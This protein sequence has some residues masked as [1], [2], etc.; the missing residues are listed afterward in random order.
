[1]INNNVTGFYHDP[2]LFLVELPVDHAAAG[3]TWKVF[4][5]RFDKEVLQTNVA[6]GLK[7]RASVEGLFAFDFGAVNS[8]AIPDGAPDG[9]DMFLIAEKS[10]RRTLYMNAY[11]AFFYTQR[12]L[13]DNFGSDRMIVTPD[14][15]FRMNETDSNLTA[16]GM[17]NQRVAHLATA[18]FESTYSAGI[19][20][21]MDRRTQRGTAVSADVLTAAADDLSALIAS[22][23]EDGVLLV[24]LFLRA[25]KAFQDSNR[26]L[27]LIT[28]WTIVERI[29]NDLWKQMQHDFRSHEGALFISKSRRERLN[30]GRTFTAAVMAEML[31]FLDYISKEVYDD[32]SAVRKA[33]NDWMHSLKTVD[34][35][36]AQ[37]ANSLCERLLKQAKGVT[38]LGAG[39]FRF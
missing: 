38:V 20:H 33:R 9:K 16:G 11:L 5:D 32:V 39:S 15:A 36:T 7:I 22:Y 6:G 30:D 25:S 4:F 19:P 17:G 14:I 18:R 13:I 2:P 8:C 31:S 23:D 24:D 27:C 3:G 35:D 12:V 28:Y 37:Q 26:S 34:I 10:F 21:H 29:I 1:M